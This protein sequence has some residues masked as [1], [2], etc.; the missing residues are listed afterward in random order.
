MSSGSAY[1]DRSD[2]RLGPQALSAQDDTVLRIE[3][4]WTTGC[5]P[6]SDP[7]RMNKRK[8]WD[9]GLLK[10]MSRPELR[11]EEPSASLRAR[12]W[13]RRIVPIDSGPEGPGPLVH[14]SEA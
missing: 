14:S 13:A 2:V 1:P 10:S 5:I 12:L 7:F 4:W 6:V 9:P 8:E 11:I 3:G